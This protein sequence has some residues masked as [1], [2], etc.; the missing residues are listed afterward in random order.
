METKNVEKGAM[1]TKNV[2][3]GAKEGLANERDENEG[4][5]YQHV[6]ATCIVCNKLKT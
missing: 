4:Y 6:R 3:K 5:V 2:E 1:E